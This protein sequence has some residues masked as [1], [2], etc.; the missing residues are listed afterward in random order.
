MTRGLNI[1]A[2]RWAAVYNPHPHPRPPHTQQHTQT[3]IGKKVEVSLRLFD[4]FERNMV[5]IFLLESWESQSTDWSLEI[6]YSEIQ[7]YVKKSKTD[8]DFFPDDIIEG[9]SFLKLI[10]VNAC[11]SFER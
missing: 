11:D 3:I 7:L 2:D 4:I 10:G 1:V 9:H 6:R 5:F 8:F